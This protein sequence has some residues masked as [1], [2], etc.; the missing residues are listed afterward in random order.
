MNYNNPVTRRILSI[1]LLAFCTVS[2]RGQ[3]VAGFTATPA[4]GCAPLLVA[5]NNTTTPAT[6][7]TYSWDLGNSTGLI[8]LTN[9]GTSYA[10]AGTY[11][12]T[13]TATHG[14]VSSTHTQVI[15]V[16]PKPVVSF[17]VSDTAVCPGA[18]VTFTSTTAGGVPGTI[19][20]L[21]AFGDG[22]PFRGILVSL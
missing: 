13:L 7:T 16:Y 5:F 18:P 21:W 15:T 10:T 17:T 19:S 2:A 1:L 9:P 11:T 14:G 22:F 6:G 20:Y 12:V 3:L 8:T 4:A